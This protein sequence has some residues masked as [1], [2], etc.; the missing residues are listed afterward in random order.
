[1]RAHG[2]LARASVGEDA[3]EAWPAASNPP[4][5]FISPVAPEGTHVSCSSHSNSFCFLVVQ[6]ACRI[7]EFILNSVAVLVVLVLIC[8][9]P[10]F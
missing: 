5:R 4:P 2:E 1:M 7:K 3:A 10:L 8:T 6:I 9:F